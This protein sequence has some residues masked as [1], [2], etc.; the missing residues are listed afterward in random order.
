MQTERSLRGLTLLTMRR[1]GQDG[2]GVRTDNGILDVAR[3]AALLARRAPHSMDDLLQREEGPR[4]WALVDAALGSDRARAAFL[5][6]RGIEYGP[7][8]SRPEK[9]VCVGLNY[10]RHA[11]ETGM[12][13]PQWPVLFSKFN[14]ALNR[15]GG[16]IALPVDLATQ[17]DYE[18]ELVIVMGRQA[19]RVSEADALSCVAGYA[20]GNDFTARDLQM[21]RGGQWM[22]G[23]TLEG[24][25]PVGPYLVTADQVDPDRLSI[26]C[27]VNGETR[28]SSTTADF[29]FGAR[30]VVSYISRYITLKPGDLIFTGTPEGVILGRRPDDRVW[31]RPGDRIDCSVGGLGELSFSLT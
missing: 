5:D 21:G 7:L 24:F 26:E 23:K 12:A 15:H 17:F 9:I 28:Q 11:E 29:I 20:T 4:L 27:R 22:I 16:T 10:R 6:E 2:L 14:G 19:S 3:A 30:Q 18:V 25:A 13:I 1:D 8:V 31:L